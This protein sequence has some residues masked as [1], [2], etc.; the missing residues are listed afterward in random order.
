[1]SWVK[2]WENQ[3]KRVI[4]QYSKDLKINFPGFCS[5]YLVITIT[6]DKLEKGEG[7]RKVKKRKE[8]Q[9]NA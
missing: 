1:M 7:D 8:A 3:D 2:D 9:E 5:V 4:F 6:G